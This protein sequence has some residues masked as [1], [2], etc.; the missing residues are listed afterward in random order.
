MRREGLNDANAMSKPR[1]DPCGIPQAT[2]FQPQEHFPAKA[3][4]IDVTVHDSETLILE[5]SKRFTVRFA[6]LYSSSTVC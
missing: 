6:L 1:R 3:K 5:N 4:P 2:A